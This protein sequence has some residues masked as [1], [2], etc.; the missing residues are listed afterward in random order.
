MLC[1][2]GL[3]SCEC[4]LMFLR[5]KSMMNEDCKFIVNSVIIHFWL[6]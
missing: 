5:H 4:I 3:N 2:L 1:K 6:E